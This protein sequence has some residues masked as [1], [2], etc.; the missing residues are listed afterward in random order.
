MPVKVKAGMPEFDPIAQFCYDRWR[1]GKGVPLEIAPD[2][3]IYMAPEHVFRD[4]ATGLVISDTAGACFVYRGGEPLN[5][6]LLVQKGFSLQMGR[7]ISKIVN[8]LMEHFQWGS[9]NP[10]GEAMPQITYQG[11]EKEKSNG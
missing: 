1:S 5:E 10:N 4:G 8:A 11:N 3:Y 7:D 9:S 6:F 2:R